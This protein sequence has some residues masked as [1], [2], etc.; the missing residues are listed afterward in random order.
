MF[1]CKSFNLQLSDG[2]AKGLRVLIFS[3]P[4]FFAS[5]KK[6]QKKSPAK[7]TSFFRNQ[8]CSAFVQSELNSKNSIV[9]F[10]HKAPLLNT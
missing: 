1:Y 5:P 6:K 3:L 7:I 10:K 2:Y 4:F 8:L 9:Q